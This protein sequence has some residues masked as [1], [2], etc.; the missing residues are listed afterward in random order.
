MKARIRLNQLEYHAYHGVYAEERERG[1]AFLVDIAFSCDISQ[2]AESDDLSNTIDYVKVYNC[3]SEEMRKPVNL[4][5]HL[6]VKI[7]ERLQED[8]P[9]MEEIHV[10]VTK[11]H[12]PLEGKNGGFSVEI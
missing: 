3:V 5:E 10:K 8:F 6:V 7:R 1:Q 11:V 9:D 4:L 12:P 2:A